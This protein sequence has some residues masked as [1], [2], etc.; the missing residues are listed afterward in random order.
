[1][2]RQSFEKVEVLYANDSLGVSVHKGFAPPNHYVA[3]KEQTHQDLQEANSAI[4]EALR[5]GSLRHSSIC[6]VYD[7]Y[8]DEAS[9]SLCKSVIVEELL[10]CDLA[11]EITNR[12][13]ANRPWSEGE[14]MLFLKDIAEAC[15]YAEE[16]S[17]SHRDIKPQNIFLGQ[18]R[19]KLGDFGSCGMS[20]FTQNLQKTMHGSPFF[21][22]PELK[23]EYSQII[24]R[25]GNA[26]MRYDPYK[27]DVYSLGVT[28]VYMALLEPP[29]ELMNTASLAEV[30]EEVLAKL[31]DYP[32]FRVIAGKMM[33]ENPEE[34]CSFEDI[35]RSAEGY[36]SASSLKSQ[37]P[38]IEKPIGRTNE[39]TGSVLKSSS[40]SLEQPEP[41][42]HSDFSRVETFL[43]DSD[44]ETSI[45]SAT[46]VS[47]AKAVIEETKE[48][49]PRSYGN[50]CI[51]GQDII[52]QSWT[53]TVP[54][55]HQIF[56]YV[57]SRIC[58][59][60][61]LTQLGR[62]VS[63]YQKSTCMGCKRPVDFNASHRPLLLKCMHCYHNRDCL[64][65]NL[66]ARTD[67]FHKAYPIDCEVCKFP[68]DLVYFQNF[69]GGAIDFFKKV[70]DVAGRNICLT[71]GRDANVK[72][73][74][75][76]FVCDAC[77]PI[78]CR[79]WVCAHCGRTI[80]R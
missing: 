42:L 49:V 29:M 45:R 15:R 4:R 9:G 8:L 24:I 17:V 34:R 79:K 5:Q 21:L 58:S 75:Q 46:P 80:T 13:K 54:S 59:Q 32:K 65:K 53:A 3:I 47:P 39:S 6:R 14:V 57:Y 51:C 62:T 61:C 10:D 33:V 30:T 50:C 67:N 23:R 28:F 37:M 2:Q 26:N 35:I 7:C 11:M 38:E 18:G 71:C 66:K 52:D 77:Y 43:F 68:V 19:V 76:H 55:K 64:L 22:S 1:M 16:N 25:G 36:F 48:V 63:S 27:S 72:L 20:L 41:D 78:T 44:W 31:V 60:A 12:K 69:F 74:C 70:K 73:P 40:S 56:A